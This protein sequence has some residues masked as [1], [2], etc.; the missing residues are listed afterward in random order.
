MMD[1]LYNDSSTCGYLSAMIITM[2]VRMPSEPG[3][4]PDLS[5]CAAF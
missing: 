1:A 2:F 3:A 5:D 4:L